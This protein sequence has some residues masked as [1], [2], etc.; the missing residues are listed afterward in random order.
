MQ[1]VEQ[2]LGRQALHEGM[3]VLILHLGCQLIQLQHRAPLHPAHSKQQQAVTVK[4]RNQHAAVLRT[5]A[6]HS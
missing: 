3:S 1:G 2:Y 6:D 5:F 4:T